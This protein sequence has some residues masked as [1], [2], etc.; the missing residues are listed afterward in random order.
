MMNGKRRIRKE[1]RRS[2]QKMDAVVVI[3][4]AITVLLILVWGG[5]Y[6]RSS[7]GAGV[8]V[9]PSGIGEVDNSAEKSTDEPM[10]SAAGGLEPLEAA[11]PTEDPLLKPDPDAAITTKPDAVTS[12]KP[13][14]ATSTKPSATA[15]TK[16]KPS[17]TL[18]PDSPSMNQ[19]DLAVAKVQKYEQELIKLQVK[20]T[21]DMQV[22]FSGAETSI[23]QLDMNAPSA[24]Q[25]WNEKLTKEIT[26]AES[27]C[28]G[29]FQQLL[30]K[31]E[32]DS[33]SAKIIEEWTQKYD[34]FKLKL[35]EESEARLRLLIGG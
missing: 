35:H 29:A 12:A 1:R 10:G 32:N 21:K 23:Q 2:F 18:A 14:V 13:N 26:A 15:S 27:T 5:L 16:V 9:N 31:A 33:V 8:N 6:W 25:V 20:Y 28:D 34:T 22:I 11:T 17:S 4:A 7:V 24:L 3:L 19:T 30:G